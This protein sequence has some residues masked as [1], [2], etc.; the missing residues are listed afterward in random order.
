MQLIS[1][2]ARALPFPPF[3]CQPGLPMRQG[4]AA[5]APGA[6][7]YLCTGRQLHLGFWTGQIAACKVPLT[8][9]CLERFGCPP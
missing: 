5:A 2:G 6:G 9:R 4:A 8:V 3:P 1:P 7:K